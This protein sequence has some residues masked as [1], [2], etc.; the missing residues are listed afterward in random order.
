M[1]LQNSPS[2]YGSVTKAFHWLTALLILTALPLGLV[3]ENAPYADG[4]QLAHK[5]WLF[6]MH[7]TVGVAAFL[8]ALL[9]IFWAM[10]Q[11]RPGLLN[12]EDKLEALG[13]HTVHWLLYGSMLLVPLTG[14]VHHAATT[15]FAPILWPFGQTLP[16]VPK[17]E[18]LADLTGSLHFL[19]MLVLAGSILAHVAGALKHFVIDRDQTLQRMMPGRNSAP[20]AHPDTPSRAPLA[21]AL[22]IWAATLVAGTFTGVF[23]PKHSHDAGPA[24][25]LT[26]AP[27]DWVVETGSLEISV[28]QFGS[29]VVGTFQDWTAAII[30]D[31]TATGPIYGHTDVTISIPSL[32]LGSVTDQALGADFLRAS[33]YPTANFSADIVAADTGYIADGTL[34]VRGV[35]VPVKM[36]FDLS[37][38]G[39]SATMQGQTTLD[40]RAFSVGDTVADEKSL[41]Y[42][43][44]VSVTLVATRAAPQD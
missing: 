9:R 5:A 17:N 3:A 22:V 19:F 37:V 36:P 40:R 15:G 44:Q 28:N 13:A 11:V 2:Q 7:K 26:Q 29:D 34:T 43:V 42:S 33:E 38:E 14:W 18:H 4:D 12:A 10:T 1:P 27:T 31:E 8:T 30:F 24:P 20:R 6:S 41:G 16:F 32:T 23:A 35:S 25:I 21:L 39:N